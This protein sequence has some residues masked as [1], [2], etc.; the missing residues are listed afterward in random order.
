M[1]RTARFSIYTAIAAAILFSFFLSVTIVFMRGD[2]FKPWSW[3]RRIVWFSKRIV[4]ETAGL[5]VK[6]WDPW[7]DKRVTADTGPSVC[8]AG[9]PD[10]APIETEDSLRAFLRKSCYSDSTIAVSFKNGE[11]PRGR[12]VF[13]YQPMAEPIL[14]SLRTLYRL[15]TLALGQ[16]D[17]Y[18]V[19]WRL[20]LWLHRV[21]RSPHTISN[22]VPKVDFN[23]NALDVM[24]RTLNGEKFWCSEYSTS[25]VQCLAALGFTGRYVMLNSDTGGHVTVE[26]WCNSRNKWIMLDPFFGLIVLRDGDVLNALEIHNLLFD[27]EAGKKAVIRQI[28]STK[29]I[30][31]AFYLSLYRDLTVQMRNDWFTNR[32]PRWHPLSTSVMNAV[33]WRDS[34]SRDNVAFKRSTSRPEDLYWP[35]NQV[36]LGLYPLNDNSLL[37]VMRTF[38]PDFSHFLIELDSQPPVNAEAASFVWQIHSG[39]NSIQL[40]PVNRSGVRGVPSRITICH[41][42]SG[43][44]GE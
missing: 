33:E 32:Y 21:F 18:E 31:K 38:T 44:G 27:P 39:E 42:K 1:N 7:D 20:N 10:V 37:V 22:P 28:D 41:N 35:L 24:H 2:T 9:L 43:S 14:D 15:D 17:D 11:L 19:L 40:Q 16:D 6:F 25:L 4:A 23:F 36:R 26:A 8:P 30:E 34:L 12:Y 3:Q 29:T 13:H 5:A